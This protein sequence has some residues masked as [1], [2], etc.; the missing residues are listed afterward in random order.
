MGL[1]PNSRT[2]RRKDSSVGSFYEVS[3]IDL[4][5]AAQPVGILPDWDAPPR[6]S[7]RASD[8]FGAGVPQSF[9]TGSGDNTMRPNAR[10]I[11]MGF[12]QGQP[13]SADFKLSVFKHVR[14][15]AIAVGLAAGWQK[16]NAELGKYVLMSG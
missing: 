14:I 8:G 10:Y 15:K 12:E 3:G 4:A 6:C 11:Q 9:K 5:K 1:L 16:V 7:D 13:I 2:I